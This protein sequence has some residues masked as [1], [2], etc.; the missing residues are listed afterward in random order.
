ML[1]ELFPDLSGLL[2]EEVARYPGEVVVKARGRAASAACR[3]GRIAWRVH[4]R[5]VRRLRDVAV[6]GLGVVVESCVCRIRCEN[7]DCAAVTFAEQV[8]G[9]TIPHSRYTPL[10]HGVLTQI[11]LALAGRAGVRMAAAAG[12]VVGRDTLLRL[13]R[14]LPDP[15]VG[16]VE[17]LGVDDFDF[18]KGRHYGTVL[19]DMDTHRPLHLFDG[20]D[21]EDLAAWL[22]EHPEI[23]VICRDRSSGYGEG[24][25][26][27]AP[28]AEQV[29]DRFHLCQNLGQAVEKTVSSLHSRLGEPLPSLGPSACADTEPKTRQPPSELKV[30]ARLRDQ[31]AAVHKLWAQGLPKSGHRSETRTPPGHRPQA[32][33]RPLRRRRHRQEPPARAYRRPVHRLP[34]STLE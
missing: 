7:P 17:V 3:C 1:L 23:K 4:G 27:G 22:R 8:A 31:H 12:V 10:L 5:Y 28:Q 30:V 34:A 9:L 24:S 13:V 6:G 14:A 32:R 15:K 19:I 18:R 25:R 33:Q 21:G 2:I 11:G 16:E 29:A 26:L 20:R